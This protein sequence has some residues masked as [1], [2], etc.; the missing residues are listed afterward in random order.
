MR[1]TKFVFVWCWLTTALISLLLSK[2]TLADETQ[3]VLP[4]ITSYGNP[5][6]VIT[7][8][9]AGAS[10]NIAVLLVNIGPPIPFADDFLGDGLRE[11]F[12]KRQFCT[13][14]ANSKPQGCGVSMPLVPFYNPDWQPNGCGNGSIV[15]DAA[16]G[17]LSI[18]MNDLGLG[19]T[20]LNN[21]IDGVDFSSS[22]NAHD[23]C[24]GLARGQAY[25]DTQ[26]RNDLDLA[27]NAADITT[28]VFANCQN[29][30]DGYQNAVVNWGSPSYAAAT[31][32]HTCAVWH[33][34]MQANDC[35]E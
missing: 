10:C 9:C 34:D 5:D 22:C 18:A 35:E 19:G 31:T 15:S 14:L 8:T 16:G 3:P 21:P 25:C 33:R 17:L 32:R 23:T 12:D 30:A 26:F 1:L 7:I 13:K 4:V 20:G 6:D 27:C 2:P 29:L 11:D 24:Y 28:S